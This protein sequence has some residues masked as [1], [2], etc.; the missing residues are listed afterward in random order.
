[1]IV[2]LP[3]LFLFAYNLTA[4]V[5]FCV[6]FAKKNI[7]KIISHYIGGLYETCSCIHSCCIL[8]KME[9]KL[10]FGS[11]FPQQQDEYI[12]SF[13]SPSATAAVPANAHLCCR[14]AGTEGQMFDANNT[15]RKA[16]SFLQVPFHQ[17]PSQGIA[18]AC[19]MFSGPLTGAQ[20]A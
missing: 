19:P 2:A 11:G 15:E 7:I 18:N 12:S 16:R 10:H 3:L 4:R 17:Q 1:M 20:L 5:V 14:G 9:E 13:A 8:F 6:T